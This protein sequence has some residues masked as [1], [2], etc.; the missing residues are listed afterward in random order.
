MWYFNPKPLRPE[1]GSNGLFSLVE[2]PIQVYYPSAIEQQRIADGTPMT[3]YSLRNQ[4]DAPP[5]P[6]LFVQTEQPAPV[7][8][9]QAPVLDT[10]AVIRKYLGG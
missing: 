2:A 5:Q 8:K 3:S 4:V 1:P 7:Q 10:A 6:S 9:S